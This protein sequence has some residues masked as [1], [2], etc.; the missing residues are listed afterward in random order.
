M[1]LPQ[2]YQVSVILCTHNPRAEY[3]ER[4]LNALRT[5]DMPIGD[6][7]WELLIIDNASAVPLSAEA[8]NLSWHPN[9]QVI[10][11]GRL[12]LSHARFRGYNEARGEIL[13][14]VDDDNVLKPD[15]IRRVLEVLSAREDLGAI[16]GK[17]L[18]E[19]EVQPPEWFKSTGIGL[20]C[21]DLGNEF[22]EAKWNEEDHRPRVYPDCAPIG[23]GMAIRRDGFAAYIAEASVDPLRAALGRRGTDLASG[24]DN[25]LILT[26]LKQG[27]AIAYSPQLELTHLIPKSRLS[28]SYLTRY[29]EAS[30]KTWVQ[31]LSVHGM[32]PWKPIPSWTTWP[33]KARSWLSL[34]PWLGPASK[35]AWHG[36]CGLIDGQASIYDLG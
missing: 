2:T 25:D 6:S 8:L 35:I 5:Q 16:G 12:G 7:C 15:Y 21:R 14:F 17:S 22:I 34:K 36:T 1:T 9:S 13:L 18:P 19:Y 26:L 24:E 11:E 31:L 20:A 29:A 27:W 28:E 23:A 10:R 33:R 30:N 3:L 4:T 32:S